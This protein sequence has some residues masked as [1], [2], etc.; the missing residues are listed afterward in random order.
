MSFRILFRYLSIAALYS[1]FLS[2]RAADTYY[3]SKIAIADSPE[4]AAELTPNDG[5]NR[6]VVVHDI[7]ALEAPDFAAAVEPF[8][9]RPINSDAVNGIVQAILQYLRGHGAPDAQVIIPNNQNITAG[10]LRLAV[11]VQPVPNLPRET[12]ILK[13]LIITDSTGTAIAAPTSDGGTT[14][15]VIH[16]V[17]FL[18]SAE[19][20]RIVAKF[21]GQP[22]TNAS[23]HQLT[24]TIDEYAH[25]HDRIV[26]KVVVPANQ[27]ISGGTLRIV[28]LVGRYNQ[29]LYRG[30]HWFS[31]SLLE[32]KLGIKPGDEVRQSVLEEAVNWANGNPFRQVRVVVNNLPNQPGKADLIVSVADTR[33]IRSVGSYSN[34]G[35]PLLGRNQYSG[36]IQFGDLW[37]LDHQISYQYT[38]SNNPHLFQAHALD[39]LAPLPW[40]HYIELSASYILVH[41]SFYAGLLGQTGEDLS[42]SVRYKVPFGTNRGTGEMFFGADFKES[43]TNLEYGGSDVS[44]AKIDI[45]DAVVGFSAV[46]HDSKGSWQCGLSLNLSPGN[47]N[48]RNTDESFQPGYRGNTFHIGRLGARARY[49]TASVSLQRLQTLT[50]GWDFFTRGTA[51]FATANLVANEQLAIGGVNTVRGFDPNVFSGEQGFV[52]NNDLESPTLKH[53]LPFLPK[54]AN[55]LSARLTFFYDAAQVFYRHHFPVTDAFGR[56][57]GWDDDLLRPMASAGV[58]LRLSVA[59]NLSFS[60]D[61]GWQITRLPTP[62]DYHGRGHIK[63]VLAF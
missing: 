63:V 13:K 30:N 43:N 28:V 61:Y 5:G 6:S 35:I 56:Q 33:P 49:A 16:G 47:V 41:P 26:A 27:N 20:D 58:G 8:I 3:L 15:I 34:D 51:Q 53:A 60:F 24:N 7:A 36:S 52:L 40:R 37:G 46:R 39:Y 14:P 31:Q 62:T 22:I 12:Y 21:I 4:K 55:T 42:T 17:E 11:I 23:L 9:G 54:N 50:Q 29:F 48:S 19:F 32:Q 45:F 59:T 25:A 57:T 10:M 38:R 2:A 18:Q 1:I 44:A